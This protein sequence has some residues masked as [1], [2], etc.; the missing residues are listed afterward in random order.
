LLEE[1]NSGNSRRN[2]INDDMTGRNAA[3]QYRRGDEKG[4]GW[5]EPWEKGR[6]DYYEK[7]V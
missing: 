6:G 3:V 4:G 5:V 7:Y 2:G 1:E